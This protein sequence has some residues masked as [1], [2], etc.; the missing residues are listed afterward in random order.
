MPARATG[1]DL[2]LL[3]KLAICRWLTTTEIKRLYFPEATLNAVQKRLR[4]LADSGYLRSERENR[5]AEAVHAVGSKGKPLVEERGI[6]VDAAR[7][8]PK[9]I[10]HMLGVNEIRVAVETGGV[11]VDWFFA[12]WQLARLGWTHPV[13]PDAVF[14]VRTPERRSFVVEYDRGTETAG[15]LLEKLRAY[16]EGLP[17]LGF[18]AVVVVTEGRRRLDLLARGLRRRALDVTV[19]AST[20]EEIGEAGVFEALFVELPD[21][22]KRKLLA[23]AE[24]ADEE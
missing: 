20:V 18:E 23:E 14:A 16:G 2:R 3:A 1:R 9:Q 21:G 7:E 8:V 4:K 12:Y 17:G 15:K 19:L 11:K 22:R 5:M 24:E 10:E 6:E 13:I